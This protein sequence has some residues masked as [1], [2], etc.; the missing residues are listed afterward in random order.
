[1]KAVIITLMATFLL[2]G[3]ALRDLQKDIEIRDQTVKDKELLLQQLNMENDQLKEEQWTLLDKLKKAELG[4]DDLKVELDRLIDHNKKI[5][6]L[7]KGL[8]E[9]KAELNRSIKELEELEMKR[10][11]ISALEQQKLSAT[12]KKSKIDKLNND[13]KLHLLLG[14]KEKYRPE[15]K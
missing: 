6:S 5:V 7:N 15:S 4:L 10:R 9:N 13:I 14:L 3:C 11:Q 12:E 8:E 1:M 2:A